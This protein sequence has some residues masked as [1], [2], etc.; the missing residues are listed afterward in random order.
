[1]KIGFSVC[2]LGRAE[3][4][5]YIQ[6]YLRNLQMYRSQERYAKGGNKQGFGE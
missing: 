3:A 5:Y 6:I 4:S 1:M 2:H